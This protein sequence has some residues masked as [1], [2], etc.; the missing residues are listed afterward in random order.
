[1]NSVQSG[2]TLI[3]EVLR[4]VPIIMVIEKGATVLHQHD[5]QEAL[6][7]VESTMKTVDALHEKL[8]QKVMVRCYCF[9]LLGRFQS[10]LWRL[11]KVH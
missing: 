2:Y 6:D 9:L 11:W 1:M 3:D 7:N 8:S 10:V 4:G 5:L